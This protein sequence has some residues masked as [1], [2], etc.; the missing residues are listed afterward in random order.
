MVVDDVFTTLFT[1]IAFTVHRYSPDVTTVA[2]LTRVR[3]SSLRR[4]L[5]PPF[6]LSS[7]YKIILVID[8]AQNL[9]RYEFGRFLSQKSSDGQLEKDAD[10]RPVLSPLLHGLDQVS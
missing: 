5:H 6:N 2:A 3:F 10:R 8:E 1:K 9:G 4:R 7:Q